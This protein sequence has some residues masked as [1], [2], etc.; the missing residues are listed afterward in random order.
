MIARSRSN[1]AGSGPAV[2]AGDVLPAEPSRAADAH[3]WRLALLLGLGVAAAGMLWSIFVLPRLRHAPI[4]LPPF[5]AWAPIGS[6]QY[7]ANGALGYLYSGSPLYVSPPLFAIVLAPVAW[8]GQ[9]AALTWDSPGIVVAHPTLWLIYGPVGLGLTVFL[10]REVRALAADLEPT[11]LWQVQAAAL[12]LVAIPV[13]LQWG[14][15]EEILAIVAVLAFARQ[16]IRGRH[17]SAAIRLSLAVAFAWWAILAV[18]IAVAMAPTG[19]RARTLATSIALPAVLVALTLATDWSHASFA[20]LLTKVAPWHGHPAAWLLHPLDV[21]TGTTWR[22][23]ALALAVVVAFAVRNRFTPATL[24][25]SLSVVL[26]GRLVFEPSLL[27]YF[28]G[29]GLLMLVL[30]ERATYGTV[31]RATATGLVALAIFSV[32][33]PYQVWWPLEIGTLGIAA[34]P[35]ITDVVRAARRESG[36]APDLATVAVSPEGS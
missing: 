2:P 30:H 17:G 10:F 22:L 35:T 18:P 16:W 31:V 12:V 32:H 33:A 6:A 1:A 34:W 14:H 11:H 29:A 3:P 9:T 20:L 25:A 8:I 7:V 13:A 24:F 36:Q 23:G 21:M 5:D 28:L 4:W 19:R 27:C 15:Y 26:L